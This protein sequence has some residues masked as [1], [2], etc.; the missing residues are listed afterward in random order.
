M[1]G[2]T[3]GLATEQIKRVKWERNYKNA[4]YAS[5]RRGVKKQGEVVG[6]YILV[7]VI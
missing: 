2:H 1:G 3:K 7:V 6:K 5:L 4:F